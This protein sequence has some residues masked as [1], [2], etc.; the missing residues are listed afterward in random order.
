[1]KFTA[2]LAVIAAATVVSASTNA[3]R[4]ARGLPPNAPMKR[5]SPV[6][7]ARRSYPST[8]PYKCNGG[9]VHCCNSLEKAGHGGKID[10]LLKLAGLAVVLDDLAGAN[11]SPISA[12]SALGSGSKCSQQTVCCSKVSQNGL[13]NA[14]CSP[15]DISG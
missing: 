10:D 3:E 12:V 14:G 6:E 8:K 5:A 4:L 9:S 13:V 2:I 1:M 15:I 7:R 11:C